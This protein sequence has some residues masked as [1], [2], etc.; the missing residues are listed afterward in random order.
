MLLGAMRCR[1]S[2]WLA[3]MPGQCQ[4]PGSPRHH[5]WWATHEPLIRSGNSTSPP[6]LHCSLKA[7]TRYNGNIMD[8][9]LSTYLHYQTT[10]YTRLVLFWPDVDKKTRL[11]NSYIYHI[12][13]SY[14]CMYN[15]THSPK[16]LSGHMQADNIIESGAVLGHSA[17]DHMHVSRTT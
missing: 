13:C 5:S 4:G 2:L 9:C 11:T 17:C 3:V 1:G 7:E 14:V 16:A 15:E 12:T 6:G 10:I 8:T